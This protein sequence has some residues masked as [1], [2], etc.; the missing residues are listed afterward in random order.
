MAHPSRKISSE[1]RDSLITSRALNEFI[2][3][4]GQSRGDRLS[5]WWVSVMMAM[6]FAVLVVLMIQV[7]SSLPR[8][9]HPT[10]SAFYRYALPLFKIINWEQLG[11]RRINCGNV[12]DWLIRHNQ[13][14]Y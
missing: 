13:R 10:E 1:W 8:N 5:I 6:V 4:E 7:S 3:R 11:T 12:E 2:L 14:N 9:A